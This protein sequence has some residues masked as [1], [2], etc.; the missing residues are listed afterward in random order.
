MENNGIENRIENRI[1]MVQKGI[2]TFKWKGDKT[3]ALACTVED[4]ERVDHDL[5]IA[6]GMGKLESVMVNYGNDSKVKAYPLCL[7]CKTHLIKTK[8]VDI[9][10]TNLEEILECTNPNCSNKS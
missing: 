9:G 2:I 7:A 1:A 4:G 8:M 10:G 5:Y 6:E 3:I